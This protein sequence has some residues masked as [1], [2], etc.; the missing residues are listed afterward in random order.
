M[1]NTLETVT[2]LCYFHNKIM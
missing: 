2:F 1:T